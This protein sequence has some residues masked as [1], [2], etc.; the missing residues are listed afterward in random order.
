MR[1]EGSKRA[2]LYVLSEAWIADRSSELGLLTENTQLSL[3]LWY[4]RYWTQIKTWSVEAWRRDMT[5]T[6]FSW[7][8]YSGLFSHVR[9]VLIL[10]YMLSQYFLA[11]FQFINV[12]LYSMTRL[13]SFL[14]LICN[15]SSRIISPLLFCCAGVAALASIT[16]KESTSLMSLLK[17]QKPIIFYFWQRNFLHPLK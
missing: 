17:R 12:G 13:F 1:L 11:Q 9:K 14:T 7:R 6:S 4:G 15:T 5:L 16:S 8:S 2:F 3:W 10:L